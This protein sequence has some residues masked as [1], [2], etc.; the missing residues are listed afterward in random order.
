[1]SRLLAS[2]LFVAAVLSHAPA[3]AQVSEAE[4]TFEVGVQHFRGE[5]Y[6]EA[7][8]AFR[9]SYRLDSSVATMCNLALTYDRMGD[10]FRAQAA[11]AYRTCATDDESGQYRGHAE[12]RVLEIERALVLEEPAPVPPAEE[13]EPPRGVTHEDPEQIPSAPVTQEPVF[14]YAAIGTGGGALGTL[15]AAIAVAM[16]AQSTIDQLIAELGPMPTIVV[17]SPEEARYDSAVAGEAASNALYVVTGVLAV[18][19]ATLITTQLVVGFGD[20]EAAAVIVPT[21]AGVSGAVAGR[22]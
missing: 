18:A 7:A 8:A 16:D 11:R 3:F 12:Q 4:L 9:D 5:R 10:A 1:M 13:D 21:P 17:G 22:F 15:I 20:S 14:L 2:W 6:E 19:T